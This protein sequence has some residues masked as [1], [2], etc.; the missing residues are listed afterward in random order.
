MFD[1]LKSGVNQVSGEELTFHL[2]HF[3][4]GQPD[5]VNKPREKSTLSAVPD[6]LT[7]KTLPAQLKAVSAM[8]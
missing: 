4:A 2:W 1:E 7:W 5:D 6:N 8:L 3:A